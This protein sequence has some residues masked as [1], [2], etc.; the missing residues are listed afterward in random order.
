MEKDTLD[1]QARALSFSAIG[2]DFQWTA[3]N[4][5]IANLVTLYL[6]SSGTGARLATSVMNYNKL[7]FCLNCWFKSN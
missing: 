1:R 2:R 6:V 7:N 5:V 4:V 3:S